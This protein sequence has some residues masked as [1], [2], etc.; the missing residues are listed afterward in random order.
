MV[1]DTPKHGSVDIPC[2]RGFRGINVAGN[3]QVIAIAPD[4]LFGNQSGEL[5]NTLGTG[6]N[7]IHN[8]LDVGRHQLI[9]LANL[10]KSLGSVNKQNIGF[11]ALLAQHHNDSGNACAKENVSGQTNNRLNVVVLNQ[12]S[13]NLAFAFT[14]TIRPTQRVTTEQNAMR[15][16]NGHNSIWL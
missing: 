9:G 12:I 1:R 15:Q 10:G 7:R 5:F 13:T 3:I 14:L 2:F 6:S 16:N 8:S 11:L 4:F